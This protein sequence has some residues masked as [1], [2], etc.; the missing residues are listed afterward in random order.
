VPDEAAVEQTNN[1]RVWF[2]LLLKHKLSATPRSQR[3]D[4][5][6][7]LSCSQLLDDLAWSIAQSLSPQQRSDDRLEEEEVQQSALAFAGALI[8]QQLTKSSWNHSMIWIESEH[9]HVLF[10]T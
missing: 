10:I 1:S 2:W 4:A 9:R 8:S 3:E 6:A 7:G 5:V